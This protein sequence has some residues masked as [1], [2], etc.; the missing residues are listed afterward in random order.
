MTPDVDTPVARSD[1][2]TLLIEVWPLIVLAF[3]ISFIQGWRGVK[4]SYLHRNF[5]GTFT[6]IV[7]SSSV[8]ALVAVGVS[9]LLELIGVE[10]TSNNRL[11]ITILLSAGGMKAFDAYMRHK[12]NIKQIDPL[13]KEHVDMLYNSMTQEE[14][15]LHVSQCAFK[16]NCKH[17]P[18]YQQ[19]ATY[20]DKETP[21]A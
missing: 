15:E 8:M 20:G 11:G 5:V 12:L 4:Q 10:D 3:T 19:G 6:N 9:L 7:L 18:R 2:L 14:R 1:Y 17:C 21:G 13:N 16:G